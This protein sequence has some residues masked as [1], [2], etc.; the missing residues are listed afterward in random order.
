MEDRRS[1]VLALTKILHNGRVRA[2]GRD[3][4]LRY[5]DLTD[6]TGIN[7]TFPYVVENRESQLSLDA[8]Y[9]RNSL[10]PTFVLNRLASNYQLH[11]TR[12]GQYGY[13][14]LKYHHHANDC[15]C[16]NM[17]EA[18]NMEFCL[19]STVCVPKRLFKERVGPCDS[20][21]A[22]RPKSVNPSLTFFSY[23][24]KNGLITPHLCF[25]QPLNLI[26]RDKPRKYSPPYSRVDVDDDDNLTVDLSAALHSSG[27][28]QFSKNF[29]AEGGL[30][31]SAGNWFRHAPHSRQLKS[32]DMKARNGMN[33]D[34]VLNNSIFVSPFWG[35]ME[36]TY[37]SDRLFVTEMSVL[38]RHFC[39]SHK[40]LLTSL[41]SCCACLQVELHTKDTFAEHW[42]SVHQPSLAL[43]SVLDETGIHARL[44]MGLTLSAMFTAIDALEVFASPSL[45]LELA[46]I[47]EDVEFI[48]A[49][50]GYRDLFEVPAEQSG[51]VA[52][53]L[54]DSIMAARKSLVPPEVRKG[55]R[56]KVADSSSDDS[57]DENFQKQ[58]RKS[59]GVK[60]ENSGWHSDFGASASGRRSSIASSRYQEID[61]TSGATLRDIAVQAIGS[62]QLEAQAGPSDGNAGGFMEVTSK[63]K[64][65]RKK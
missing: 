15:Y 60:R 50:G 61:L 45:G 14:M 43:I 16:S 48:S 59:A 62:A 4:T 57:E 29:C 30:E 52:S 34:Y 63:R 54:G 26:Q 41:F 58:V 47:S 13:K 11:R 37:C 6:V 64:S 1:G 12:E 35:S 55:K 32:M 49:R 3:P 25:R 31:D 53:N 65:N 40:R 10:L 17:V 20:F 19:F 23:V 24:S 51:L 36:C 38:L 28:G 9:W 22:S 8:A 21:H 56:A 42:K 46:R 39:A 33:L 27:F 18:N 5:M 2:L 7:M 44:A